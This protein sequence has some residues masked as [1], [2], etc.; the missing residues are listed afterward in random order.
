MGGEQLYSCL[1]F[2]LPPIEIL[3]NIQSV[4][5]IL[6]NA[7]FSPFTD[8]PCHHKYTCPYLLYPL[9]EYHTAYNYLSMPMIDYKNGLYFYTS[10]NTISNEIDVTKLVHDWLIGKLLNKGI[11]LLG[12]CPNHLVAYGSCYSPYSSVFP[13]LRITYLPVS[14]ST[15]HPVELGTSLDITM[16]SKIYLDP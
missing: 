14:S 4:K 10:P 1:Y 3:G 15:Y 6:F 2:D 7:P 9:R 16:Q 13:F 11:I 5:L 8:G 12:C